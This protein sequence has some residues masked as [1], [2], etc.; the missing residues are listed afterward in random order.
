MALTVDVKDVQEFSEVRDGPGGGLSVGAA[1][2]IA[3]LIKTLKAKF[4]DDHPVYSGVTRHLRRVANVQVR[5]AGSW[6]GNLALTA[7]TDA[8]FPSDVGLVL[9]AVGVTLEVLVPAAGAEGA[10][11]RS[12][13]AVED[14]LNSPATPGAIVVRGYFPAHAGGE[15]LFYADKTAQRHVNCHSVVNAAFL[16]RVHADPHRQDAAPVVLEA[17]AVL[18]GVAPSLRRFPGLESSLTG[19][20]L[21]R[22]SLAAALVALDADI[23]S[24][25]FSTDPQNSRPYRRALARAFTYKL[26][27]QA[28][29]SLP[30]ELESAVTPFAAGEDR[31]V[32]SGNW[33]FA[34]DAPDQPVGEAVPKLS[35][36]LQA[37]GEAKY[38]SD[39]KPP[40]DALYGA[41]VFSTTAACVLEGMDT[42]VCLTMPGVEAVVTAADVPGK[43]LYIGNTSRVFFSV[44]DRVP[45]VGAPL[46]L[47]VADSLK[48]ARAAAK[49]VDLV[50]RE[51]TPEARAAALRNAWR[52]AEARTEDLD[53]AELRQALLDLEAAGVPR[54]LLKRRAALDPVTGTPTVREIGVAATVG[55]ADA[56]LGPLS[57][58]TIR[59]STGPGE[60]CEGLSSSSSST[61]TTWSSGNVVEGR[62]VLDGQKHFF[63]ETQ[64]ALAVP[65]E[66]GRIKVW[67]GTQGAPFTQQM[68][69]RV[70]GKPLHRVEVA[71]RRVGGAFG[72]KLFAHLGTALAAAVAAVKLGRPVM[73]H[74]ERLDDMAMMGGREPMT[75][76][77]RASFESDGAVSALS[78]YFDLDGGNDAKMCAGDLSMAS[79]WSDGCYYVPNFKVNGR[80]HY[81][82]R[83]G[84]T[85]MR[86]PGNLQSIAVREMV[87]AHVAHALGVP[88]DVVQ[89]RNM[90]TVGQTTPFG[91]EIGSATFNWTVPTLWAR[92]KEA[93]AFD[94]RSR[95][96]AAFNSANRFRKRGLAL[97]PTKYGM[98]PADYRV[99]ALINV[100]AAD[101][102]VEVFHSGS[103]IGQGINTKVA[104]AVAY[105]LGVP[106]GQVVVGDN[107][108]SHVPNGTLTGGSGTSET[109]VGA[110]LDACATLMDRLAPYLEESGG[111]WSGAVSA[112]NDDSVLL[113]VTGMWKD[114]TEYSGSFEYATQGCA[115]SEVEIDCLTGEAQI[116]RCDLH[117]DL[118]RSLNP[119]VDL[120]QLQGGF[121]MSLGYFLTEEV[122]YTDEEVQLNLGTFNQKIPSAYD[123]PEVFNVSLLPNTPNPTG[124]LS[125]KASG[126]PPMALAG[127]TFLA[128]RQAIE[129]C[130]CDAGRT[131]YVQLPVPLSVQAIQ[132]ACLTDRLGELPL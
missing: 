73:M 109:C 57:P 56:V 23:A 15:H 105:G 101:G 75:A 63:M 74:N 22:G 3:T 40:A 114:S 36:L 6:A 19:K 18:G 35:A 20:P 119:A 12:H 104:Q 79:Q 33:R 76:L 113:S 24:F 111:D 100:Y 122:V 67:S 41:M 65:D 26:F 77:Y 83:P 123:I 21:G 115:F 43:N 88:L 50:F 7:A 59:P 25:G 81:S 1:T 8:T 87:N 118:G 85:S 78:L 112:A 38:T 66:D 131:N 53:D 94:A 102:T 96:V 60:G 45:F 121:V 80:V 68:L 37:S 64:A 84:N 117:M 108:T 5:G 54:R 31:P 98:G 4:G 13:V 28:Q 44:G 29:P 126:E 69:G 128:I 71:V 132:Q 30:H 62:V 55:N 70:L 110:A 82:P 61:A 48:H 32:S 125:S 86:A 92:I 103:E 11:L 42:S 34:T 49:A 58:P 95:A 17:R 91:D 72:G 129:A 130:R 9:S 16:L 89:E 90:Y 47:V 27:L 14:F 52:D 93:V 99:G 97:M 46:A 116:L 2:S 120:G 127:S 10:V 106:L 39:I 124:V 51:R 107:S